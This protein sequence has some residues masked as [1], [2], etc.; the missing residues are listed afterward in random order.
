MLADKCLNQRVFSSST[1]VKFSSWRAM[2][3]ARG[4]EVRLKSPHG[5]TDATLPPKVAA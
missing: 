1:L 3:G 4:Q 2:A 5:A